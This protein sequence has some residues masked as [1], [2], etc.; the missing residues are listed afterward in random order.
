[1]S[2]HLIVRK[3]DDLEVL[4]RNAV[5]SEAHQCALLVPALYASSTRIEVK[6]VE[7]LVILHL[8]YMRMSRNEELRRIG[9]KRGAYAGVV[10][11]GIASDMFD[12]HVGLLTLEAV[13]FA[14][15]QAQVAAVAVT[16]DSP[17]SSEG[18][19]FLSHLDSAD[20][21]GVPYLVAGL[22]IVQV[23]LVP[24]AVRVADD[25]NSFHPYLK[26]EV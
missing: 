17:E 10:V 8:Q 24:I 9:E 19:Q 11:T 5:D 12:E 25:A 23:F 20:V 14:V 7:G 21:A 6:Q 26:S 4:E 2:K 1:M 3:S 18:S 22:E 16:A 15:H 13:Q